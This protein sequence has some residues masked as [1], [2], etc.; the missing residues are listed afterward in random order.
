[1]RVE[2]EVMINGKTQPLCVEVWGLVDGKWLY[3][4]TTK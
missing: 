2:I 3:Y 1:M 4:E